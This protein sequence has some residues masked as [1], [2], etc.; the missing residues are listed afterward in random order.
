MGDRIAYEMPVD[1]IEQDVDSLQID[2]CPVKEVTSSMLAGIKTSL[3]GDQ[4][5][6]GIR[7]FKVGTEPQIAR[8]DRLD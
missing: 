4:A 3:T 7:V 8:A 5:R 2:R 1:F 6:K